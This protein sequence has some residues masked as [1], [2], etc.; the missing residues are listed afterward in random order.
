MHFPRYFR[1]EIS[2]E[3]Y[4]G[5]FETFPTASVP[6][7]ARHLNEDV[8]IVTGNYV[9]PKS[10]TVLVVQFMT[11]RLE[12]YYP[13]PTVFDPDNFLPERM[14]QRHYYAYIPFSAG[15]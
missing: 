1:D 5:N 15:P 6:L 12:K 11:H 3:S 2:R 10:A 4:Y 8:T 9:L 7:I 14:Q 13:N